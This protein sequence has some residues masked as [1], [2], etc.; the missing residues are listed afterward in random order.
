MSSSRDNERQ[1]KVYDEFR[2]YVH[3]KMRK[4]NNRLTVEPFSA[5][6]KG[7]THLSIV[8]ENCFTGSQSLFKLVSDFATDASLR[9]KNN[10]LSDGVRYIASV[11]WS[12]REGEGDT[13][14]D[15]DGRGR[16]SKKHSH[17]H[18]SR[19]DGPSTTTPMM[20]AMALMGTIVMA[21]L[22]TTSQQWRAVA[23]VLF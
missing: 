14:D 6:K 16:K 17:K 11:P 22:T 4:E 2:A 3:N 7:P 1:L 15:D 18:R 20:W 12:L 5:C 23:S 13:D 9:S 21:T 8:L 10:Q 19:S